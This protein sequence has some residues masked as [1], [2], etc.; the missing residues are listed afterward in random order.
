MQGTTVAPQTNNVG[1]PN[2][3]LLPLVPHIKEPVAHDRVVMA[4]AA[5]RIAGAWLV[6]ITDGRG[7]TL[8]RGSADAR[9]LVEPQWFQER[10]TRTPP[11]WAFETCTVREL[12]MSYDGL[13]QKT[14][15][16][17]LKGVT[18]TLSWMP[19]WWPTQ[20][21][22]HGNGRSLDPNNVN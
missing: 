10:L 22:R 6:F 7:R 4:F 20:A 11:V 9:D 8:G 5:L 3:V 17:F 18:P 14:I 15:P 1:Y 2:A 16:R 13:V 19:S 12:M 21:N